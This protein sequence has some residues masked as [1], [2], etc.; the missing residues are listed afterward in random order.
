MKTRKNNLLL[1]SREL[2]N[3]HQLQ[4]IFESLRK[5]NFGYP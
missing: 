5:K 1:K 2:S 3:I 4:L